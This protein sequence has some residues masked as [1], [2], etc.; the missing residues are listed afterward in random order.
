MNGCPLFLEFS[1]EL[2]GRKGHVSEIDNFKLRMCVAEPLHLLR[3]IELIGRHAQQTVV[4]Q[5]SSNGI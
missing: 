2:C 3:I 1:F 5:C 4:F